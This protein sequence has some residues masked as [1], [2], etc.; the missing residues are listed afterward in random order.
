MTTASYEAFLPEVMPNV[1]DCP[2]DYAL[3]AIRNACIEFCDKSQW[4]TYKPDAQT[5][6]ADVTEYDVEFESGVEPVRLMWLKT[7]DRDAGGYMTKDNTVILAVT[8]SERVFG[9]LTM[10]IAVRPTR[11]STTVDYTVYSR[12]AE[13]IAQGAMARL[14]DTPGQPFT[15]PDRAVMRWNRFR[16]AIADATMEKQREL[17][18]GPLR[19]RMR[20][21]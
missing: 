18:I 15:D 7:Y 8:P 11:V 12:W 14:Y 5:L 16:A 3:N 13:A 10:E 4:L 17:T 20:S 9:G 2:V 6:L 19:V 1:R 21:F